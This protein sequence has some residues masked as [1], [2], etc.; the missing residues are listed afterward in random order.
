[1]VLL[2]EPTVGYSKFLAEA[3]PDIDVEPEVIEQHQEQAASQQKDEVLA[4][5]VPE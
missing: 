2:A 3:K 1:M 5:S 4:E